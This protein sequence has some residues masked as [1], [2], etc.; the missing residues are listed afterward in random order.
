MDQPCYLYLSARWI[1][2]IYCNDLL[3]KS[4]G[5]EVICALASCLRGIGRHE[6]ILLF[7]VQNVHYALAIKAQ[8]RDELIGEFNE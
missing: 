6:K 7:S 5:V 1:A 2:A 8:K 4:Y 3:K